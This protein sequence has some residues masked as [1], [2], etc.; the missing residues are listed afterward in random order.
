M[1][2][3]EDLSQ[4]FREDETVPGHSEHDLGQGGPQRV[5]RTAARIKHVLT[6]GRQKLI[7]LQH[8]FFFRVEDV[9]Y[10]EEEKEMKKKK[11]G[12]RGDLLIYG[13]RK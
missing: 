2:E 6:Q 13:G 10:L 12:E 4:A 11:G 1:Y 5:A 9:I 3:R 8:S 7:V